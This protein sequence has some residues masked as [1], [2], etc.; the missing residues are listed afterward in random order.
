MLETSV[1]QLIG[2]LTASIAPVIVISGVGL[3]L[4]SMTN[5]YGRVILRARELAREIDDAADESRRAMLQEQVR[6]TYSRARK[7]RTAIILAA[8]SI[9]FVALT[10]LTLFAGLILKLNVGSIA[11]PCFGV[12]LLLL[13]GSLY[14]FIQD[15]TASLAALKLEVESCAGKTP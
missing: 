2:I 10:V 6:L 13:V 5:G 9:L 12:S 1:S 7:L 15:V 11:T 3:L 4:L 14:Y 8:G